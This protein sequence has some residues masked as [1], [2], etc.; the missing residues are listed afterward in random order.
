[1]K[2]DAVTEFPIGYQEILDETNALEFDQ[3]SDPLC[4]FLLSSLSA[5]KQNGVFLEL[6][7]GRKMGSGL[8]LH[9]CLIWLCFDKE[10]PL[11][12]KYLG[13]SW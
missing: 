8:L 4:G 10:N 13:M 12:N 7:T 9:I 1:M 2:D 6:G 3:L 11:Q 5:S